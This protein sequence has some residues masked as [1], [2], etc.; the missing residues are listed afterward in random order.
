MYK[1][2]LPKALLLSVIDI[3]KIAYTNYSRNIQ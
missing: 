1:L 2:K 3:Y